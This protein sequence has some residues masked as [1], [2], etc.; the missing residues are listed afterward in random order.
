M[1]VAVVGGGIFGAT[2]AIYA[3]RDG[4]DVTL[5]E[6]GSAIMNHGASRHNQFRLH[7]GY[8]YPRSL[9]TALGCHK[10]CESFLQEYGDA[11]TVRGRRYYGVAA[12]GS[13]T[14]FAEYM[15][16]L[17]KARLP[18]HAAFKPDFP[19]WVNCGS[20]D[21]LISAGECRVDP[22]SMRGLLIR[23][24]YE[25][26]VKVKFNH[27]ANS[28]LRAE[29]DHIV[30]AAYASTNQVLE[31]LGCEPEMFQYEVVEK[32]ILQVD[33]PE[34]DGIVI[35]DGPFCSLDP[36]GSTGLHLMGHVE[37]AIWSRHVG[38]EPEISGS[39]AHLAS[40]GIALDS[41]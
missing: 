28:S 1:R 12:Q 17:D 32:P 5:Y 34:N 16:F 30:V 33:I 8:H 27:M 13:K 36:Y 31:T 19:H 9:S 21:G 24:L 26:G 6:A 39:L 35:M 3:A 15:D 20:V 4:H 11:V 14:S 23:K 10:G 41:V 22:W 29:Y 7:M 37:E 25:A 18:Y 38:V 2:A 40:Q